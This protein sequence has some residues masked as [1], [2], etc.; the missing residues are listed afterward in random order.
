MALS[1]FLKEKKGILARCRDDYATKMRLKYAP[2]YHAMEYQQGSTI[3]LDGREM[4][5]LSS[6]DY[7]GL[8]FHPKVIEAGK[9]ALTK[10]GTS[11]TGAR[12]ANGSRA[13][14][15]QLEEKLAAFL[16]R[17]ACHIHAAGYLSC[18][19]S[20]ASFAQKG[21][22]VYADKNIH[23][24]LWDGIRLSMATVERF[25]HNSPDDL[26]NVIAATQSDAPKML[27]V[28]GV[29]SMEGHIAR[30][31]ELLNIAD[32][33]SLFSVVDDAHGFGVLGRQGRGT[34]DHHGVNDRVDVI[35]GSMSK[36]LA[37]TGGFVAASR[38]VI[39][40]LRSHSK[41]TIF[42]AAISPAQA[43]CAE[44][45]LDLMQSEPQHL[46]RLWANTR[47]YRSILKGLGLDLWGSETPAVP[48]VLGSKE[49]VYPFWRALMEK[50]VFTVMSIAPAVPAGKDLIRTAV[51]A[52]HTDEQLEKI[53]EAMA[54][55]MRKL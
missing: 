42:S 14:H 17:E 3:K 39:E 15:V 45:S 50:G 55:A 52:M 53:G 31:P 33:N 49:R 11:T 12:P 46:E 30:L 44:A 38:E 21:D 9:A 25:S 7:L 28:E 19:S 43:G 47:K 41:Q 16:G 1:F 6:N 35:C 40:Y 32:E 24:C 2:Y 54:Y 36:S 51:S 4:I 18:L 48:I 23:S 20:V 26:R 8:S 13:Y 5:M 37:S 10:W 34:V 27:V 22:V 29:Y